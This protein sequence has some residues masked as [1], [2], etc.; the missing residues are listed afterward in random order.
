[1]KA[2]GLSST[3][4]LQA[5]QILATALRDAEREGRVV[6]NVARL[7]RPP[8]R[9]AKQ[10]QVLTA[11]EGIRVLESVVDDRLGSRWAAA[12]C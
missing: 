9:A 7:V 8:R 11:E 4:A 1:M 5:Y 2:K 3:T 6:R 10:T 12:R